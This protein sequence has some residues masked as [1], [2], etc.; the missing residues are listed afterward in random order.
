M[1]SFVHDLKFGF[2]QLRKSPAFTIAAI[3]TL[4]L[5]IGANATVF[6]WFNATVVNPLRGVPGSRDLITIR[7]RTPTGSQSGISWLNYLDYRA[8][9]H[10]LKEFAVA[11]MAL[12]AW[13]KGPSRSASGPPS[14]RRI[15]SACWA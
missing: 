4:A 3:L 12:S 2:R 1:D 6:T 15:T 9:N 7:W 10:T 11:A 5:G 14:P 8:R 13:V